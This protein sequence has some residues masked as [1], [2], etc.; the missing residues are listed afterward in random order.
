M[1]RYFIGTLILAIGVVIFGASCVLIFKHRKDKEFD[2]DAFGAMM[3]LFI[4]GLLECFIGI[5]L[6]LSR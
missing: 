2:V 6:L 3:F 4:A 5:S 1:I